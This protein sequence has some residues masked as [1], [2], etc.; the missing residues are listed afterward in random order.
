MLVALAD[1]L[2]RRWDELGE[3]ERRDLSRRI[4]ARAVD[5]ATLLSN[6][7]AL[8]GGGEFA[9]GLER[10]PVDEGPAATLTAMVA[11]L[12]LIAP[13]HNVIADIASD[14]PPMR[15]DVD[16]LGQVL[17]NVV[18]NAAKFTPAGCMVRITARHDDGHLLFSVDD[19]GPDIS[20]DQR[21]AVFRKFVQLDPSRAGTGLG[22][23]IS[24]AIIEG[25]GGSIW[26]DESPSGGCRVCI[27]LPSSAD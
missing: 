12:R 11:D 1:T 7:R 25:F 14:L 17:R 16:R 22:L 8:R 5:L 27:V 15:V 10:C 20:P 21:E 4:A 2:D 23:F 18:T 26:V 3:A 6:L 13:D 9:I 24:R 19:D